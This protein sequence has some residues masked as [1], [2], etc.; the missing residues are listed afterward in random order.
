M[1]KERIQEVADFFFS[2][3][4]QKDVP[5]RLSISVGEFRGY[6][7]DPTDCVELL[8][9]LAESQDLKGDLSQ[10]LSRYNLD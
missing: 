10:F 3:D 2:S 9:I 7:L 8:T 1:T 4:S 6:D 5:L